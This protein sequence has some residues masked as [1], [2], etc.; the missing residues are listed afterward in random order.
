MPN[1]A[2]VS[3]PMIELVIGN[4]ICRLNNLP[5]EH[6]RVLKQILSYRDTSQRIQK[7]MRDKTTKKPIINPATGRPRL[8]MINP[9]VPLIDKDG[10]F[11]T[12]LLYLVDHYLGSNN[13]TYRMVD[14][15]KRPKLHQ[16]EDYQG[17]LLP[18]EP[19]EEQK[20]AGNAA[21]EYERGIIVGPTGVGKSVIVALIVDRLQVATLVVVPSVELKNQLTSSLRSFFGKDMVGPLCNG[22]KSYEITVENVDQLDPKKKI[23]GFHCVIVD[24]FHR[25][26]SMTYRTLNESCWD[27]IYFKFGLTATPFR[28]NDDERLLLESVLSQVIYDI[29]YDLAVK[30]NRIVSMEAYYVDLP[31]IKCT[32]KTWQT[33][34][35][36]LIVNRIDRNNILCDMIENLHN[37][38]IPTLVLVKQIEHGVLLQKM[39]EKRGLSVQFANGKDGNN[40]SLIEGFNHRMYP[41]LIGT[42]GV[43]GEGIDTK[44]CEY[45]ILAG[46][47]K[48]KNQFMQNVGRGFR[49]F[50]DKES[51]KVVMFRDPS[52][53]WLLQHFNE[54]KKYLAEEYACEPSKLDL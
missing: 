31:K 11:P 1:K 27:G 10:T 26:G 12:G 38:D 52:N 40:K 54:C 50:G 36:E 21:E 42:T 49:R 33:A 29:P 34:Y 37:Q 24:E 53:K 35:K 4:S 9:V 2:T 41:V 45:V 32:A 22:K 15:R 28:S 8:L 44:P 5:T 3:K 23:S 51:C 18:F 30:K 39:L 6:H 17:V 25:S 46:G 14:N 16:F 19:Y 7:I 48:S 20:W 13:I 47:G 43:L